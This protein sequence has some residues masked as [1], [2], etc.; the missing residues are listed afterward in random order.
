[1]KDGPVINTQRI[2]RRVLL[3][4]HSTRR[5][6]VWEDW[7]EFWPISTNKLGQHTWVS[8]LLGWETEDGKERA[9]GP[10]FV[11]SGS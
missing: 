8:R 9:S 1:M 10:T 7:V 11:S 5:T 4:G 2:L 6:E 3:E